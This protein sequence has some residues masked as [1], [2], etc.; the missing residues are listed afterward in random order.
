MKPIVLKLQRIRTELALSKLAGRRADWK[1][2]LG[3]LLPRAWHP[4]GWSDAQRPSPA[5]F[6]GVSFAKQVAGQCA[7]LS[8]LKLDIRA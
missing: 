8:V 1:R 2:L 5:G 3:A 7:W 6:R 4:A